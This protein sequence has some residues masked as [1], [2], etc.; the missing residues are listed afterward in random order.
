[1]IDLHTHSKYSIDGILKIDELLKKAEKNKLDYFSIT[2]H[3]NVDAYKADIPKYKK[4]FSGKIIN[5]VEINSSICNSPVE[6]LSYGYDTKKMD[7]YLQTY[8]SYK[9]KL[10]L[11]IEKVHFLFSVAD[12]IKLKYDKKVLN[13]SDLTTFTTDI[14]YNE[15]KKYPEN[16]AKFP[17]DVWD[18]ESLFYRKYFTNPN[19]KLWYYDAKDAWPNSRELIKKIH[20]FNGLAFLAHPFEY[21]HTDALILLDHVLKQNID[22]VEAYHLSSQGKEN[23]ILIDYAQ[24]HNLLTSGGS[25]FHG[26]ITGRN[27]IIGDKNMPFKVPTNTINNWIDKLC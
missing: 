10:N 16:K 15:I 8:F 4:L 19:N 3:N 24:K 9:K 7:K 13:I 27:N 25:D 23:K 14:F 11:H 26:N 6:I 21:K 12:K 20:E 18:N 17:V 1:M 2:D 5:G 22:G